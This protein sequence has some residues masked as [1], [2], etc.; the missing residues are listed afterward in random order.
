MIRLRPALVRISTLLPLIALPLLGSFAMLW[1]LSCGYRVSGKADLLPN[2]IKTIAIP[3]FA[4]ATTR[5][6]LSDRITHAVTREFIGRTRYRI[7]ADPNEADA[8]L[9]GAVVNYAVYPTVFDPFTNRAT[10]VQ[11]LV[12]L[13]VTLSDR[14]NGQVLF[15]RPNLEIRERYELSVDPKEYFD[16]SGMAME[17]LSRD[18]AR[19]MVSA[20][21]E[22]F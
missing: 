16:E 3:A 22:N 17:R 8:V 1:S 5:Y 18:V 13:Q 11:T 4:N 21:L 19:S 2:R 12:V 14:E 7:V 10:G 9:T 6:K 20:I 15:A